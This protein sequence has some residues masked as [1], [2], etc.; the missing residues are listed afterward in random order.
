MAKRLKEVDMTQGNGRL[1]QPRPSRL[2]A[3][4]GKV[5]SPR[6]III[7]PAALFLGLVGGIGL[8]FLAD[9]TDKSFRSVDEIRRRLGLPV[10]GEIPFLEQANEALL[11]DGPG[12][13]FLDPMLCT[14]FSPTSV[15][16]EA[17]PRRADGPVFQHARQEP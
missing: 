2:P 9:R 4:Q 10:V 1:P 12:G 17:F 8:A 7:F 3:R 15:E 13:K 14:I 11:K 16:A 6:A 5:V